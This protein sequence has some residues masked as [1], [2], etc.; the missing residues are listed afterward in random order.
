MQVR[1]LPVAQMF[2]RFPRLV[3]DLAR[4]LGKQV[5]LVL[6]GEN[7]EAD[8]NIIEG[9]GDPLIHLIRNSLDHGIEL[10]DDR[11][12]IGKPATGTIRLSASQEGDCVVIEVSDD[13]GGIDPERMK[14][15][16]LEKRMIDPER[17]AALSDDE[18]VQLIFLPGFSTA[19]A[20]TD[21]SGRGV[22]MDVVRTAVEREGGRLTLS[23]RRGQ[24]TTCRLYLPLSMAVT[25]VMMVETAGRLFGVPMD[26]IAE[27]VRVPL[28]GLRRIKAAETMVLRDAIIPVL[29]LR[30]LLDLPDDDRA[31]DSEAVM[32]VRLSNL[33]VGVVIDQFKEGI[34]I[35]L[36]PLDGLIANLSHYAGTAILGDGRVLLV[37][38]MRGVL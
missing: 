1:M 30:R 28:A 32:V 13:G 33:V 19:A 4:K 5:D 26:V 22:G 34:D 29:R 36:K 3:R 16:A 9:L 23:S 17:A 12:D 27:T 21:V 10:P 15:K 11:T 14:A 20:I 35:I 2:Q 38:N 6:V 37:L 31:R 24:G 25:R 7:T 8:K 18:A